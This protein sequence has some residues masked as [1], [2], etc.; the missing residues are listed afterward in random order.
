MDMGLIWD[1]WILVTLSHSY[2]GLYRTSMGSPRLTTKETLRIL[3]CISNNISTHIL[4]VNALIDN[5]G[6]LLDCRVLENE[7]D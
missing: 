7:M 4:T 6:N 3:K 2:M 1:S 5:I